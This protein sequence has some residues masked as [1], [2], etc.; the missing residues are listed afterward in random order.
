MTQVRSELETIAFTILGKTSTIAAVATGTG[1]NC[2]IDPTAK[3]ANQAQIYNE[4]TSA[5][6]FI[7]FGNDNTVGASTGSA[8]TY[9]ADYPVAPGAVVVVTI[10]D[11]ATWVAAK[12]STGT[13]NVLV[14]PGVGQ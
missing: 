6:A 11:G 10:P 13:G 7:A 1:A 9:T 2:Q 5:V 14:T 12:L 3:G 4:S 8:S